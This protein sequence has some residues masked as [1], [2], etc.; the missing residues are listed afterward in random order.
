MHR[1]VG[2][3]LAEAGGLVE[4]VEPDGLELLAPPPLQQ[5][6]GVGEF[7]RL[8]FGATLPP[9]AQRVG[10]ESDWLDRFERVVGPRGRWSRRVVVPG[11]RRGPDAAGVLERE[12]VLE[13]ATFRLLDAEPAWT[14]YLLLDFRFTA[15]SEE[16]REGTQRLALNLA[17]GAMPDA[18]FERLADRHGDEDEGQVPAEAALP[19]D[20]KRPLVIE[21]IRQALPWRVEAA[22]APFVTAL[23]RRLGR[24]LD[25]L[26]A[27]HND[28][29]R[30]ALLRAAQPGASEAARQREGQRVAAI[31]QEY[32]AKL[33]DLAHKYALRVSVGWVQ[34]LE[35]VMPV[36]RFRVQVRRRKAERVMT[37]DWNPI[38]R[39][40]EQPPCEAS[41][42]AERPRL[43]CDDALH[44]VAPAGLAACAGCERPYCRA[45]HPSGCPKCGRA[46]RMTAFAALAPPT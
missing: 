39:R 13:N 32:R 5:A 41:W 1:F 4:P 46:G 17:T 23:R 14:R 19:A 15:L 27:Y 10:I 20:W 44:L 33:D 16:K 43:V 40:L 8:G 11:A 18:T 36:H 24:D 29:H 37:M 31:A 22:L 6:L 26:H 30:E 9:G 7:S 35:V 2:T 21:R 45:C 28:L 42:S 12:L 25:R 34:T 3:L 38:A